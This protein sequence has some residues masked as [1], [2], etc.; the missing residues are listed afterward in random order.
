M[1]ENI[2]VSVSSL[3]SVIDCPLCFW[4][5]AKGLA[6]P[7]FPLPGVLSRIDAIIK[8][9]MKQFV[10]RSDLPAW[11][12]AKGTFLGAT[13]K[14]RA[15]DPSS[16]VTLKG[17]LDAVVLTPDGRHYIVDYKTASPREEVP[18][19]YR[20]QLDGYAFLLEGNGMP[21][22]GGALLYFTPERGDLSEGKI[23]F[24][25]TPVRAEVDSRRVLRPLMQARKIL[26]MEEPPEP[27]DGCQWCEWRGAMGK[28]VK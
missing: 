15:T 13:G 20:M 25:I 4:L 26:E 17:M 28:V 9:Y 23:P 5:A 7:S 22:A 27:K 19:Y 6:P 14:L 3:Q 8:D 12:P 18:D 1:P 24:R 11:F 2:E 21:V 16:G 10:G